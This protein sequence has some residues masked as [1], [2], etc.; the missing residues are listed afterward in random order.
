MHAR[1]KRHT[2]RWLTVRRTVAS[3]CLCLL[4]LGLPQLAG[5]GLAAPDE[6]GSQAQPDQR[7]P[8]APDGAPTELNGLA[9]SASF[10]VEIP[11]GWVASAPG[12]LTLEYELPNLVESA[13]IGIS[14]NDEFVDAVAL[15]PL[16]GTVQIELPAAG[17][18]TGTNRI[19]ID[20]TIVVVDDRECPDAWHPARVVTFGESSRVEIPLEPVGPLLLDQL[21]A[22]LEPVGVDERAITVRMAPSPSDE[23]LSAA[24]AVVAALRDDATLDVA[25]DVASLS[26]GVR[27]AGPDI[28]IGVAA[29]LSAAGESDAI[30]DT[31]NYRTIAK[32]VTA[33]VEQSSY[34]LVEALASRVVTICFDDP[35]VQFAEVTVRKP[36]AVRNATA[37]G[38]TIRRS[39]DS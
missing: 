4:A 32:A 36:G 37:V 34:G 12:S 17:F 11:P 5:Q 20:A 6:A 22:A 33:E 35:R 28:V 39:H 10:D 9:P 38:V 18:R 25:L 3:T 27:A 14:L 24:A 7:W 31:V 30:E 29:D 16:L 13:A 1:A 8:I 23:D 2:P 21:P 19:R 15:S 26:S